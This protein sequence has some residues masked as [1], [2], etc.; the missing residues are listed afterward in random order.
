M[1]R[2]PTWRNKGFQANEQVFSGLHLHKLE[3]RSTTAVWKACSLVIYHSVL[4]KHAW[5][6]PGIPYDRHTQPTWVSPVSSWPAGCR[7][8]VSTPLRAARRS[9]P[10]KE[11]WSAEIL[12]SEALT[13]LEAGGPQIICRK[14]RQL[15]VTCSSRYHI[16][17]RFCNF[18]KE[19]KVG[20]CHALLK[21]LM[22]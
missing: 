21:T 14:V 10:H 15:T 17:S 6:A 13:H 16:N 22:L 9:C 8:A 5:N 1:T 20:Q 4:T 2:E 7:T 12:Y 11:A 18:Q 3:L 19:K